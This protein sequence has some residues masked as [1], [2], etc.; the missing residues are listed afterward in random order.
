LPGDHIKGGAKRMKNQADYSQ[1]KCPYSHLKKECGHELHG[2]EGY[3]QSFGVWCPCGFR[4]PVFYL[5]PTELRLEKKD[6]PQEVSG[7]PGN[8]AQQRLETDTI[9]W[10]YRFLIAK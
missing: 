1:Y 3:E 8:I 10:K 5:D 9:G 2:P 6:A 7:A 4:A